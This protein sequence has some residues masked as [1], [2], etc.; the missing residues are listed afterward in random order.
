LQAQWADE[1]ERESEAGRKIARI[2]RVVRAARRG[3]EAW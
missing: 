1:V 2:T 3:G